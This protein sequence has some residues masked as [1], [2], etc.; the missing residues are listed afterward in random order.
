MTGRNKPEE[1]SG[2]EDAEMYKIY[3]KEDEAACQGFALAP[4]IVIA[5]AAAAAIVLESRHTT[6]EVKRDEAVMNE[7]VE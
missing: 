2:C 5:V 4:I 7:V 6:E 1:V 3:N